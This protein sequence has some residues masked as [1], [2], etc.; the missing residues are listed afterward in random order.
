MKAFG[1]RVT[2]AS[3]N[4]ALGLGGAT[5]VLAVA[6]PELRAYWVA[7]LIVGL[8]VSPLLIKLYKTEDV[9]YAMAYGAALGVGM[10]ATQIAVLGTLTSTATTAGVI[11]L[12]AGVSF[13][14]AVKR[15]RLVQAL[16]TDA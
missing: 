6:F 8:A 5:L 10:G 1:L 13:V 9:M 3:P 12:S 14:L 2:Q 16:Q 11:P 4:L 15:R 7:Q